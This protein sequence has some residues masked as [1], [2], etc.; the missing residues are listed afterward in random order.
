MTLESA[1]ERRIAENLW[2]HIALFY[3][4]HRLCLRYRSYAVSKIQVLASVNVVEGR[5][6]RGLTKYQVKESVIAASHTAAPIN[7]TITTA[8]NFWNSVK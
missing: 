8:L 3:S 2:S 4:R 1:D 6:I 7:Q 5:F